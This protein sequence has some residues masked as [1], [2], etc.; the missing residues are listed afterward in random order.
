M[1][2]GELMTV[3]EI[4]NGDIMQLCTQPGEFYM[5]YGFVTLKRLREAY[6]DRPFY[7]VFDTSILKYFDTPNAE[8][9][10]PSKRDEEIRRYIP[11]IKI[12]QAGE[13]REL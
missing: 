9:A 5:S 10:R 11:K 13:L 1:S 6:P 4:H 2:L 12:I 7:G 3:F 8:M